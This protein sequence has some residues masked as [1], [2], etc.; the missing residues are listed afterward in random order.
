M[1]SAGAP[2]GGEVLSVEVRDRVATL[3]LNRPDKRNA[4]SLELRERI[5]HALDEAAEDDRVACTVL[6]GAGPAF[7][8]GMDTSQFGGDLDNRRALVETTERLFGALIEHPKPVVA[9]VSG[10][11]LGGG[12][13]LA[14]LSD[15]RIAD[16]S[17]SFGFPELRRGIPGS[18]GAARA[19]LSRPVALD[20]CLSGRTIGA[21]E[22]LRLGVVAEL[23]ERSTALERAVVRAAEIAALPDSGPRMVKRWATEDRSWSR[24]L[25]LE[26]DAFRRATLG[27]G[28]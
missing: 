18:Y 15:V 10:P 26:M 22:A 16:R 11:A 13:A 27:P 8:S 12:F 14:L 21:E 1:G 5:A 24:L 25:E 7:C 23:A 6:T 4:L 17:A 9:A 20:L 28:P 2:D 3:T 19:A